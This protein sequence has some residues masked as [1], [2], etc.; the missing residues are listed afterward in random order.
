MLCSAVKRLGSGDGTQE[1]RRNTR[2]Q[3][4]FPLTLLFVLSS[5]PACF[6]AEQ[7]TVGASL[8]VN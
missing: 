3:L 5:L 8:I 2:L 4:M 1:V 6:T 7:S